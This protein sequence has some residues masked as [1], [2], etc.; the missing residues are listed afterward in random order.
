MAELACWQ[1]SV[2]RM[3]P[4][5]DR[6]FKFFSKYFLTLEVKNYFHHFLEVILN[7][8]FGNFQWIYVIKIIWTIITSFICKK[9]YALDI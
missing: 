1:S 8:L 7:Y 3:N 2:R 6:V 4:T 9:M 5:R